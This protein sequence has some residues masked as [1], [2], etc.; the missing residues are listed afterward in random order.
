M[1]LEN[2][3]L[4][5]INVIKWIKQLLLNF[6]DIE[7][8]LLKGKRFLFIYAKKYTIWKFFFIKIAEKNNSI[9]KYHHQPVTKIHHNLV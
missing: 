2:R 1:R 8:L 3:R 7:L 9:K 5:D 4:S 6:A